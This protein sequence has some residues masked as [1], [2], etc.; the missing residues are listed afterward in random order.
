MAIRPLSIVRVDGTDNK[1]TALD[2]S[3]KLEFET[4]IQKIDR[5]TNQPV[6]SIDTM[7]KTPEGSTS[8]FSVSVPAAQRPEVDQKQ[9]EFMDLMAGAS[10]SNLW[11]RASSVAPASKLGRTE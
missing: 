7:V 1:Y 10:A 8:V 4:D 2:V 3:P 6:W 9:V 11:F 5:A